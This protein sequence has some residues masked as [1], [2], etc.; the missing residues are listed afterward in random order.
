[1]LMFSIKPLFEPKKMSFDDF[2]SKRNERKKEP[3]CPRPK[4]H[5]AEKATN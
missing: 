2:L 3:E 1:M 5:S 4:P